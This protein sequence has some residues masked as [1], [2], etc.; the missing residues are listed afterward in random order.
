MGNLMKSINDKLYRLN[1]TE[2][3]FYSESNIIKI[4]KRWDQKSE[5]WDRDLLEVDNHLN[6]DNAYDFFISTAQKLI[7]NYSSNEKKQLKLLDLGCGTGLITQALEPY[8]SKSIGIDISNE[9]LKLARLKNM[10]KS[11]FI[12]KNALDLNDEYGHFQFVVSRGILLSHYNEKLGKK[13][14]SLIYKILKP[15]GLLII[16]F[17]NSETSKDKQHL[18]NNKKY[19]SQITIKRFGEEFGFKNI[20]IYGKSTDRTLMAVMYR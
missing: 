6:Q 7:S 4:A 11:L 13:L 14:L 1:D 8:F 15:N 16:D 12:E 5:S 18:P 19:Y 3:S 20:E 17:L 9:M 2:S 10:T